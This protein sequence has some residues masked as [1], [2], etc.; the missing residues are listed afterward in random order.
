[1]KFYLV[2]VAL[3]MALESAQAHTSDGTCAQVEVIKNFDLKSYLGLW[4]EIERF[5]YIFEDLLT[6]SRATYAFINATTI[7]VDNTAVNK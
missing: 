6:C 1:M 2:I 4:Y 7:S 5:E 3:F